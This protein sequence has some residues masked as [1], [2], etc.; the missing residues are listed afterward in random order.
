MK[1][2][3]FSAILVCSALLAGANAGVLVVEGKYQQKNL[4][5]QNGFSSNGV[6]FCA[7]QVK[8]NGQVTTDE[9]NSSAFEIDFSPFKFKAGDKITVEIEHKDGCIPKVLNPEALKPKPTFDVVSISINND[10]VLSWT[11]KNEVG[12]LPFI[13]EQFKWNKW[14]YVGEINGEGTP[15]P[16]E[17]KFKVAPHSG[18]NKFRVK[19]VGFSAAP[20]YSEPVIYNSLMERPSYQIDKNLINFN[21]ETSYEVY[22]YYGNVV[23]KGFGPSCDITTLKKGKYYLCYD[24]AV[25]EIEKKR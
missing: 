14:V 22:D 6:G 17:Y 23:K 2:F 8:V 12:S 1:K 10:A 4:F 15:A 7:F 9:V 25:T 20:R 16:H 5:I 21:N 13:V 24:N 11:A 18:E 3:L 19:Q